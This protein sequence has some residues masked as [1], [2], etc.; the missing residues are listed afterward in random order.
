[1]KQVYVLTKEKRYNPLHSANQTHYGHVVISVT[2]TVPA[3]LPVLNKWMRS[4]SGEYSY[5]E[6]RYALH[7]ASLEDG[8]HV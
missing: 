1:M 8:A 6:I 4:E 5:V 7:N 3:N 2:N